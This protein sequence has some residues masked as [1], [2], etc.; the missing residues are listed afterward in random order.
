MYLGAPHEWYTRLTFPA[1]KRSLVQTAEH[2]K[3]QRNRHTTVSYDMYPIISM[4][5]TEKRWHEK[6]HDGRGQIRV[7]IIGCAREREKGMV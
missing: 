3:F 2:G 1:P 4:S 7:V 5:V 6:W